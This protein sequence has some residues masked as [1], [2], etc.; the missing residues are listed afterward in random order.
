MLL[1]VAARLRH[2]VL[3]MCALC[4]NCTLQKFT[5]GFRANL[6]ALQAYVASKQ[7][8]PGQKDT[9]QFEGKELKLGAWCSRMR[10]KYSKGR[11][12]NQDKLALEAVP[13]WSWPVGVLILCRK[14]PLKT[15]TVVPTALTRSILWCN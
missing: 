3:V 12:S 5:E 2:D 15:C 7:R 4:C 10:G 8:I 11:L 9:F 6:R 13:G 14:L 1:A